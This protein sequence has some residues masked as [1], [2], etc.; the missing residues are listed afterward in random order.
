MDRSRATSSATSD[1]R[2]II[3]TLSLIKSTIEFVQD[4]LSEIGISIQE[5]QQMYL[6]DED[7]L[8]LES[9]Y[10]RGLY[11]FDLFEAP[12]DEEDE[13]LDDESL[14]AIADKKDFRKFL[15]EA[16]QENEKIITSSSCSIEFCISTIEKV[17]LCLD[18][19]NKEKLEGYPITELRKKQLI[20]SSLEHSVKRILD[21]KKILTLTTTSYKINLDEINLDL[22]EKIIDFSK[23]TLESVMKCCKI[24]IE[25]V[26][27]IENSS[28]EGFIELLNKTCEICSLAMKNYSLDS[29]N[30][31][32]YDVEFY[33]R[34]L[35]N[36]KMALELLNKP[37]NP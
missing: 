10:S 37:N 29:K 1:L 23:D 3:K 4:S 2:K 20:K 19:L 15:T 26:S 21:I 18:I 14:E 12:E 11:D 8:T 35:N 31:E 9:L 24:S 22:K 28:K 16:N 32:F 6:D 27:D 5:F 34:I 25:Q 7:P 13:D 33:E 36:I 17:N 30:V